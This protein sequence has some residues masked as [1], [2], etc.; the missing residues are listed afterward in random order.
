MLS[1]LRSPQPFSRWSL[2]LIFECPGRLRRLDWST[3]VP[4]DDVR[5]AK[6]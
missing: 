4:S 3:L 6:G 2:S 5:Y 1:V